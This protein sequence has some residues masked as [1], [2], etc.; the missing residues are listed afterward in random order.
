MTGKIP[1]KVS[2]VASLMLLVWMASP[3]QIVPSAAASQSPAPAQPAFQD[4]TLRVNEYVKLQKSLQGSTPRLR[5]TRRIK[6][7]GNRRDALARRIR[8]A[9]SNAK[10]G[11]IFTPEITEQFRLAIRTTFRSPGAPLVRKTIKPDEHVR[12]FSLIVNG[13]YPEDLAVTTVPPTLLLALPPL[14]DEVAY[15]I[16]VH[17]LVLQDTKARLVI[18]FITGVIPQ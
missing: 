7:I 12:A 13:D 15:R 3:G 2:S 9:R 1:R 8:E 17:D 5:I 16:V 10:Q 18:D 14:P 6:E 4:F 11:D